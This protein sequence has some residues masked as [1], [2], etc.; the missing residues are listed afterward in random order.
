MYLCLPGERN[1]HKGR[2]V[3][4][5]HPSPRSAWLWAVFL[6]ERR[7]M[8]EWSG[9][10]TSSPGSLLFL[11]ATFV[12][13][14]HTHRVRGPYTCQPHAVLS[15]VPPHCYCSLRGAE[16]PPDPVLWRWR[17][18]PHSARRARGHTAHGCHTWDHNPGGHLPRRPSRTSPFSLLVYPLTLSPQRWPTQQG[19]GGN[20]G[21][22]VGVRGPGSGVLVSWNPRAPGECPGAGSVPEHSAASPNHSSASE[23]DGPR[24]APSLGAGC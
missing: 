9:P 14:G 17:R 23:R 4:L 2:D 3:C 19:T 24:R 13:T 7:G 21:A 10:L 20:T 11:S 16:I 5:S 18:K 12:P 15:E 8:N 6:N 1:F 22:E